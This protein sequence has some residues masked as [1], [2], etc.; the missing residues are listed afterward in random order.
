M[1]L[2][3]LFSK[4]ILLGGSSGPQ[5]S[6]S[7]LPTQLAQLDPTSAPFPPWKELE[8][9]MTPYFLIKEANEG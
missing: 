7:S 3:S 2:S 4:S 5:A 1:N 8:G 9:S 6:S